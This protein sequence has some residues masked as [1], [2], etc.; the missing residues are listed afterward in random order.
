[1]SRARWRGL[2]AARHRSRPPCIPCSTSTP[3]P[4]ASGPQDIA[5]G[6]YCL[7]NVSVTC[8]GYLVTRCLLLDAGVGVCQHI[9]IVEV[10][11]PFQSIKSCYNVDTPFYKGVPGAIVLVMT[12]WNTK[13]LTGALLRATG[14][15]K[16]DKWELIEFPAIL[17]SGKPVWPE[18]WK[19]EELEG[20]KASLTLQKWNAQWMQNPTSEEGAIIKREWWRKWDK[21][22][23]P[24]LEHVIQSYDTAFMKKQS[25]DYSAITTW[26]VF[27]IDEDSGPQLILLDSIKDRFEFPEL[28]RIAYQQYQYWQPETV[29]SRS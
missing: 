20:V 26:G 19:L 29:L 25:A 28:R 27:H 18:Y 16:S 15:T 24:P 14:D 13:D 7:A 1:M 22:Y 8:R 21:D 9:T 12:R 3:V 17:P 23:I 4:V 5:W 6:Y 10:P 11:K 2:G